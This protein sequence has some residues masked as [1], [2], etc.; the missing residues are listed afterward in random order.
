MRVYLDTLGCRLNAAESEELA[1]RFLGAGCTLVHAPA[2]AEVIVLNTC[3][4]TAQAAK[5]SR[6]RLRALHRASPH[7]QIAAIGCWVTVHPH[8]VRD[9]PGVSWVLPNAEK[10]HAVE[11]ILGRTA[12]PAPWR[13]GVWRH[14]RVFLGVQ[15]GCD[16]ACTYCITRVLRGPARSRPLDEVVRSVQ[17]LVAQDAQE[18][19]LTGVSLGAYGHDLGRSEGLAELVAAL[20]DRT[21]VPRLRLSSIEPW[22]VSDALLRQWENPRL[23]RQLHIP[24]QS[25]SDRVLRRM[26]RRI[27]TTAFSELV[28]RARDFVPEMAVTTD[29]LVGFPGE[30]EAAFEESLAFVEELAFARL[31]VFRYSER[32]GTPA[33]RLPGRVPHRV[34]TARSKRMRRLGRRLSAAYRKRFVG[35]VLPVLWEQ[36]DAEGRWHGLTDTYLAVTTC[37]EDDLYNRITPVRLCAVEGRSLVGEVCSQG[38]DLPR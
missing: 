27:T 30:T 28:A 7:A 33:V 35:R 9:Y 11:R 38:S 34:R 2:E 12:D 13:P 20:L 25:G 15:D 19:V 23:C 10:A 29:V 18:V 1:R 36:R 8:E 21:E 32:A 4:V 14:T 6:H 22:D 16:H 5:R 3:A 37:S 31:H 26:G 17:T 24:L